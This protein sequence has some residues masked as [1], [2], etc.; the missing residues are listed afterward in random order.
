MPKITSAISL[1]IPLLIVSVIM[2]G[3]FSIFIKES[4]FRMIDVVSLTV[5]IIDPSSRRIRSIRAPDAVVNGKTR[6]VE[7]IIFITSM[8]FEEALLYKSSYRFLV[9]CTMKKSVLII[10]CINI[11]SMITI[12][13]R[14]IYYRNYSLYSVISVIVHVLN[15]RRR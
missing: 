9:R 12:I 8:C 14:I 10:V 7:D 4:T 5:E 3:V 2:I 11:V 6:P 13:D 1:E 15:H